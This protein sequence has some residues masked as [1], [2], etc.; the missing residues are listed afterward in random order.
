[1]PVT[2]HTTGRNSPSS[3]TVVV[4]ADATE[5]VTVAAAGQTITQ[6]CDINVNDG[7]KVFEFT[8]LQP[9]G[10]YPYTITGA[11][12]GTGTLRTMPL[13]GSNAQ[14]MWLAFSSCWSIQKTDVLAL[15]L[16]TPP[17]NDP[18]LDTPMQRLH[19]ECVANL[20]GVFGVGDLKYKNLA[21]TVNGYALVLMTGG[22][23][24]NSKDVNQHR[25]Y[26][27]AQG[28]TSGLKD[29][30]RNV[31]FYRLA[32][33]HDFDPDNACPKSLA[34]YQAAYAGGLEADRAAYEVAVTTALND[35][36][37]GNPPYPVPGC[38]YFQVRIGQVEL[39]CSDNISERNYHADVDGPDKRMQSAAQEAALLNGF[40]SSSA[41]FKLWVNTKMMISA[42]GRNSDGWY[43]NPGAPSGGYQTQLARILGDARFPGAGAMVITGD[44]HIKSVQEVTAGRFGPGGKYITEIAGGPATID[45]IT[46]PNDGL[47]YTS[48]VLGKE[49]DTSGLGGRGDNN[50]V[51]L[52]VLDDRIE[53]YMLGSRAGL[54]YLGYLGTADN[55]I[56][57]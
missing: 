8:G 17:A 13:Q 39:F 6:T 42:C 25:Q 15:K 14:P 56:R 5:S 20:A 3:A 29:L 9:N 44:E 26:E 24:A 45:V 55:V 32:D 53:R 48:G 22:T 43:D 36:S 7:N 51:L 23:I 27:R 38:R 40:A 1:M 16:L 30:A 28:L 46:N 2:H 10:R 11:A 37:L 35:W 31:P 50:Y 52:R 19:R 4:R 21:T 57:R 18:A 49:R 12:S 47:A 41:Q 33:D 54:V 34:W